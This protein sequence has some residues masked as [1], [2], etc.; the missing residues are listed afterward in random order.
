MAVIGDVIRFTDKQTI[1][2]VDGDIINTYYYRIAAIIGSTPLAV[3]L[4]AIEDWFYGE[5]L[6]P[7]LEVQASTLAHQSL[8]VENMMDWETEFATVFPDTPAVGIVPAEFT[9]S[10]AAW[11]FQYVRETR[12]TRHGSK[13]IAAVPE[14]LVANNKAIPAAIPYLED[15]EVTMFQGWT[16]TNGDGDSWNIVPVIAK[17]PV[18]PATLP[19]IFNPVL[20]VDYKGVG[21]QNTRKRLV[22]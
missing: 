8:V 21:S 6:T 2:G 1:I 10:A 11:S 14:T 19:T 4:G 18:P 15:V 20:T 5:F 22:K 13:R 3:M 16:L 7:I 12:I 17:T 9:S